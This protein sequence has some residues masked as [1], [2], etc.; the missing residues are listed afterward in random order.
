M[1]IRHFDLE[2]LDLYCPHCNKKLAA[3]NLN[4]GKSYECRKCRKAVPVPRLDELLKHYVT[5]RL[6]DLADIE[7]D[8]KGAFLNGAVARVM[9]A[10]LRK[11]AV[12]DALT[13]GGFSPAEAHRIMDKSES[14]VRNHIRESGQRMIKHCF[15]SLIFAAILLIPLLL[16]PDFASQAIGLTFL[17][18]VV[19]G[20]VL[21]PIGWLKSK[22]G[23]NIR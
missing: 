21:I 13:D 7:E 12:L 8:E 15:T 23:W 9:T 10:G 22:T 17:T 1:G 19:V 4:F 16:A 11:Q 5:K 6:A 3:R 2:F 14:I 18:A 20:L